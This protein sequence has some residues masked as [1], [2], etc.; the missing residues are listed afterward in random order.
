MKIELVRP[1]RVIPPNARRLL[2]NQTGIISNLLG[3]LPDRGDPGIFYATAVDPDLSHLVENAGGSLD[4]GGTG[5]TLEEALVRTIAEVAERYCLY[6]PDRTR[7]ITASYQE[8]VGEWDVVDFE[9]L[10]PFAPSQCEQAGINPLS[11]SS[12]IDWQPMTNLLTGEETL[13][14]A[15]RIWLADR[16]SDHTPHYPTT[17]NGTA[18]GSSPA[19]ALVNAFYEYIER[20][21]VMRTWFTRNQ[22]RLIDL[23]QAPHVQDIV[24]RRFRTDYRSYRFFEIDSVTGIPVVG[25]AAINSRDQAPKFVM[26]GACSLDPQ[27]AYT[28]ALE[29]TAQTWV[30][31]KE[32]LVRKDTP[33]RV[34]P[35]RIFNLRDNLLYYAQPD[36]FPAVKFLV[37]DRPNHTPSI[38]NPPADPTSVLDELLNYCRDTR[39]TPLAVD[40][41]TRDI[42]DVGYTVTKVVIPELVDL[43]LPSMPPGSHPA[44]HGTPLATKAHP[45]P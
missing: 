11:R 14:P 44:F 42:H 37:E 19:S 24:D 45:Y 43:V 18:C 36:H 2:G 22:P 16:S 31:L 12:T 20:D 34:D 7:L 26:G 21:A 15:D 33:R 17:S 41:T 30:Y 10:A 1:D 6:F 29:E 3:Y 25:C 5:L 13:V 35:E 28:G 4:A 27:A 8:L 23:E 39:I 38:G 9:Y 40:V 32:L